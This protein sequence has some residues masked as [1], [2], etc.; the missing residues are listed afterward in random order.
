MYKHLRHGTRQ[1]T[2]SS[3]SK[4]EYS[5]PMITFVLLQFAVAHMTT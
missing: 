1:R 2:F 5:I 4:K 3:Q